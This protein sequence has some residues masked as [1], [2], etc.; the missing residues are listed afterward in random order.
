MEAHDGVLDPHVARD[1]QDMGGE[2]V[3]KGGELVAVDVGQHEAR[4]AGGEERARRGRANA[5]RTA[6]DERDAVGVHRG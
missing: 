5:G 6:G 2:A 3:C 4:N 1:G